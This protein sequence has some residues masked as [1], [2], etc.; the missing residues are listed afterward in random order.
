[1]KKDLS[2]AHFK[3][4]LRRVAGHMGASSFPF[5]TDP[6]LVHFIITKRR[7]VGREDAVPAEGDGMADGE[8][9]VDAMEEE[10]EDIKMLKNLA[11]LNEG[12]SGDSDGED[13]NNEGD[14]DYDNDGG[15]SGL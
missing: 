10:E 9:E 8:A 3:D 11:E 5:R 6:A 7:P 14:R 1:M 12:T 4:H 2:D 15:P 13:S